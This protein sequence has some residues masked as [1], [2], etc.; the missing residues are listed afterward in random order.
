MAIATLL[1][2]LILLSAV[3]IGAGYVLTNAPTIKWKDVLIALG[4]A[5]MPVLVAL[6]IQGLFSG[7]MIAIFLGVVSGHIITHLDDD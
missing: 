7:M 4:I 3:P 5:V 6:A 1:T 2:Q